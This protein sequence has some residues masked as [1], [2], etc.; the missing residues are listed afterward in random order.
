MNK[1]QLVFTFFLF[2]F[3]VNL[4]SQ[5]LSLSPF[6]ASYDIE[7]KNIKVA[8]I[9]REL[10]IL[11][12]GGYRFKT[13]AQSAGIAA[14]FKK[15]NTNETSHF[16]ITKQRIKPTSYSYSR[17]RKKKTKSI[18]L[19]FDDSNKIISS[20]IND[21]EQRIGYEGNVLDKLSAETDMMLT[22]LQGQTLNEQQISNGKKITRYRFTKLG[23]ETLTISGKDFLSEKWQREKDDSKDRTVFWLAKELDYLPVQVHIHEVDEDRVSI[24]LTQTS[25]MK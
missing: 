10:T 4:S 23:E 19:D 7:I 3:S 5:S 21:S 22:R 17:I 8:I 6:T 18:E 1:H 16:E 9:E 2:T 15:D 25:K 13:E 12:N 24:K 11:P 14:L 20:R